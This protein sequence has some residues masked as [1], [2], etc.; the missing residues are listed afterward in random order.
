MR[1]ISL[2]LLVLL[3]DC[4]VGATVSKIDNRTYQIQDD[5][6]PGGSRGPDRRTAEELCPN[7]YRVLD[8]STHRNGPDLYHTEL[9][10]LTYTTWTVRCL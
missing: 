5:G 9:A 2:F 1:A 6:V 4:A 10:G 7:G 8:E 3:A